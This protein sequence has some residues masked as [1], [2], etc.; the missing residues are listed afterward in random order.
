MRVLVISFFNSWVTH[1]GTELEIA[2]R[3]LD[4]GDSVEFL[5]CDGCVGLCDGNPTGSGGGCE[6]CRV[7]RYA[8][9]LQLHPRPVQHSLGRY[10][11]SD[12]KDGEAVAIE[13]VRDVSSA[14]EFRLRGADLGWGAI[15]SA[16]M[17]T[18]DPECS[19]DSA[20]EVLRDFA[21]SAYR[22]YHAVHR[23]LG[24]NGSYDR[25]YIFNGRFACTRGALRACHAA[26]IQVV[27]THERGATINEFDLYENSLPHSRDVW[28]RRIEAAWSE[29]SDCIRRVEIGEQFYLESRSGTPIGW[30][31]FVLGQSEGRLPD[32]W[33]A[34]RTNVAIYNSSEDEF[35]GLGDEWKNPVYEIQS[36]GIEKI[37]SESLKRY[38][39]MHFY[40]RVHPNLTNVKNADLTRLLNFQSPNFTVVLPDSPVSTYSLMDAADKVLSFGSTVG[41]EATYWGKVSILAGR[42]FYENLDAVHVANSHAEVMSLLAQDLLPCSRTN[43]LKYGYYMRTFGYPFKYWE[44]SG[45]EAGTF[46]G[47]PIGETRLTRQEGKFIFW[48]QDHGIDT[49]YFS[50]FIPFAFH[51]LPA[52]FARIQRS[53]TSVRAWGRHNLLWPAIRLYKR[54]LR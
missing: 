13:Q 2:Q 18:R 3:H 32:G 45:F 19:S 21:K 16:I 27:K 49:R 31:S 47:F 48:L 4:M 9:L 28:H 23:F 30:K 24:I 1:F 40:L 52:M 12:V 44:P 50:P 53:I 10:L 8:G 7:R 22:S 25:V 14:R 41:I 26:G 20:K 34:S 39:N 17:A 29:E 51:T 5:G 54:L 6:L 15:S 35:A 36:Q 43:A 38:P 46:R 37:V 11:T 42:C 33:D